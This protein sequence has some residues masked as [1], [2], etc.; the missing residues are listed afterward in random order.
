MDTEI[1]SLNIASSLRN[2][3]LKVTIEMNKRKI[4]KCFEWANKNNI[5]YVTVIGED[6][7]NSNTINIKNMTT[8]EVKKYKLENINEIVDDIL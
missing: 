2:S 1:Y 6:E 7:I 3:G 4:K 5:P 8:G